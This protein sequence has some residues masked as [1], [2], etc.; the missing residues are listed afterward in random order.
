MSLVKEAFCVSMRYVA[1][2]GDF[3]QMEEAYITDEAEM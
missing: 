3:S 1:G 2:E